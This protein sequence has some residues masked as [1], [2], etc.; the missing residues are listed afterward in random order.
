MRRRVSRRASRCEHGHISTSLAV[1][2]VI[3]MI[4]AASRRPFGV[5]DESGG[6]AQPLAGGAARSQ[7]VRCN[8][9]GALG[10]PASSSGRSCPEYG[11]AR[12]RPRNAAPGPARQ[13]GERE[14]W[15]APPLP[16]GGRKPP[17]RGSPRRQ[18]L[19]PWLA[20]RLEPC[21]EWTRPLFRATR[22][23]EAAAL[24]CA[25]L[26]N[27]HFLVKWRPRVSPGRCGAKLN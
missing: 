10:Q 15:A 12:A 9:W 2:K 22:R 6:G 26:H 24:A 14:K 25:R 17:A 5:A 27:E 18:H 11:R 3:S 8:K 20:D 4:G 19:V 21:H 7:R 13:T 16:A 1:R 23:P